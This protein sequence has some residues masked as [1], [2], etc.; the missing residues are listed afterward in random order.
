MVILAINAGSS[1]VKFQVIQTDN[2]EAILDGRIE[3]I[4]LPEVGGKL[5]VGERALPLQPATASYEDAVQCIATAVVTHL[6]AQSCELNAV[7]HRVV[8]GGAE[9]KASVQIDAEVEATIEALSPLAPLHNPAN[10][11]AIRIFKN[12]FAEIPHVAVFDTAFHQS[13]PPVAYRYAVPT[14][15]YEEHKVRRYGFHGTSHS[16]VSSKALEVLELP[17][18]DSAIIVAHL[19][20]G[21]SAT[22][23]RNG[24]SVDTTMGISP[25]EGL[26]MG[27][28]SGSLDPNLIQYLCTQLDQSVEEVT[29]TLNHDSGLLGVSESS[30]DM[31]ELNA[32]AAEGDAKAQLAVEIFI[33]RL[34]K[35]VLGLM[36]AFDRPIDA[37]VFTG[38]IGENNPVIR[39]KIL[40]RLAWMGFQLCPEQ[41]EK[42][43]LGLAGLITT[44]GASPRA[45]VLPTNEELE[46][47]L[48]TQSVIRA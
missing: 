13:M 5:K 25:L 39:Q 4:G 44:E 21:C 6:E 20:N 30:P 2:A 31:R 18:E 8:H 37:L 26:V 24:L 45:L 3:K 46:I 19:G 32:L 38:G 41:N 35:E 28:R 36:A 23:V 34:A 11:M 17:V 9:F 7:G 16:Y 14:A 29:R 42:V 43:R 1:S 33:Y 10:L 47:V 12:I 40:Q 48:Q 15:W 22:A 27:T